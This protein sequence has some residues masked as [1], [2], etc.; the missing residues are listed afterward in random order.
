MKKLLVLSGIVIAALL[1][2]VSANAQVYILNEDF[3]SASGTTPP[4]GW[5]NLTVTG[6]ATDLWRFDNPGS[7]TITYPLNGKEYR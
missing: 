5:S 6:R 2:A 1:I 3:S 4:N 7:R